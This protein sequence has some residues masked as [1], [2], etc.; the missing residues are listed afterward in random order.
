MVVSV[1]PPCQHVLVP[2]K[3]R[4]LIGHPAPT[5]HSNGV[6]SGEVGVH[7]SA[8]TTA[9]IVASLKIPALVEDDLNRELLKLMGIQAEAH[10][11]I[12]IKLA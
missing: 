10:L 12:L 7:V 4:L 11:Y 1:L 8:V 6:T 9:L 3:V 2:R 5:V